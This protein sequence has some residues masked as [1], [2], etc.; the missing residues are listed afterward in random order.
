M[1]K[2]ILEISLA[3]ASAIIIFLSFSKTG[4]TNEQREV[5]FTE[6]A[7]PIIEL[8]W[9]FPKDSL[10][11]DTFNVRRNQNLSDILRPKGITAYQIDRIAKNSKGVFDV[12]KIKSGNN[13]YLLNKDTTETP[14][15]F[16]YKE[17]AVNYVVFDFDSLT[18]YR[19]EKKIDTIQQ[20]VSGIIESS[21][22]NA[23]ADNGASPYLAVELS[24]IFAWTVDFFGIQKGDHF[25]VLFDELYVEGE[26]AGIG[27]I[28]ATSFNHRGEEI[29]AYYYSNNEQEGYFDDEGNSLRKAFLKVPLK[30]SRISSGYNLNRMHPIHKYRR[31]HPGIDYAAPKGTPVHSIGDGTIVKKAY[32][33]G[34]AGYYLNIK[35]NSV[36]TSQYMH[37]SRYAKGI[38]PGVR[39]KQGQVIA[40]VGS[41]GGSTGPHLDFRI[42]KNGSYVNPM[43]VKAP[44]VEPISELNTPS[45]NHLRDSLAIIL[46][47]IKLPEKEILAS[48]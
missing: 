26:Y 7:P 39:V 29:S 42:K 31:P 14:E 20:K 40:Y 47:D 38:A 9:G 12:R 30:F 5:I 1:K 28:Y 15:V 13:Y 16:I 11:I 43:K 37:L 21:L 35:H 4:I 24:D 48:E 32:Q 19:G 2:Y 10:Q 27:Q 25:K 17:S 3:I 6:S 33:K 18:V 46:Q 34:G 41:T 22:W 23:F 45:F 44:P 8:A 36:Y